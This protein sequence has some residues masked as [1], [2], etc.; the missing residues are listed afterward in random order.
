VPSII[1]LTMKSRNKFSIFDFFKTVKVG[2]AGIGDSRSRVNELLGPPDWFYSPKWDGGKYTESDSPYWYYGGIELRFLDETKDSTI[3]AIQIYPPRLFLKEQSPI[4]RWIFY[5]SRGARINQLKRLL[6]LESIDYQDTGLDMVVRVHIKK[7]HYE[8]K[9]VPY[10]SATQ[11]DSDDVFGT[12]VLRN[13][14]Q[15]RYGLEGFT[16]KVSTDPTGLIEVQSK[17]LSGIDH[18]SKMA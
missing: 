16:L 13:G 18:F 10:S 7:K 17:T 14:I 9:I 12:V 4:Y 3:D 11:P 8:T 1:K 5:D 15:V 2:A 6:D